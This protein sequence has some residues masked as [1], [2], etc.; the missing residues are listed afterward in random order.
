[1]LIEAATRSTPPEE[2]VVLEDLTAELHGFIVVHSTHLGPA[3]G[4]CRF[5]D[6][7]SENESMTDAVRLAEGMSYKNALAGLPFGGGK[8]VI[9]RPGS[10]F[11]RAELFRA[12][13]RAVASLQGRYITAEDVG[14]SVED[15]TYVAEVTRHVAGLAAK[16]NTPGGDPSPWTA[17]GVLRAMDVAVQRHL[18]A[19]LSDVTVAVQGLGNVGFAL[20]ALLHEAGARLIVAER[21]P[22]VAAR[23]A[24]LFEAQVVDTDAILRVQADVLAPCA[25][26]AIL[27]AQTVEDLQARIVC[28]AANNQLASPD[29]GMQLAERGVL[30]AP[31]YLVNAGGII[32]VA[33]EILGW[34]SAEAVRRVDGIGPRLAEV[35]DLAAQHGIAAHDAADSLAREIIANGRG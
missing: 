21:R 35:L 33:A 18:G 20:C 1:M 16:P 29:Q 25:L 23:A 22:D 3:V 8:A 6:Y 5:W 15:M 14:T 7:A 32:N 17:L 11:D 12:F 4:G 27:D 26:G 19:Q 30:Y 13:G 2:I 28:G 10:S 24:E 34:S 9:R 31:D